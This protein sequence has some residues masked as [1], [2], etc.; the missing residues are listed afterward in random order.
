MNALQNKPLSQHRLPTPERNAPARAG[1]AAKAQQAQQQS[2]EQDSAAERHQS[3]DS[4][5]FTVSTDDWFKA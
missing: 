2:Q 1:D 3:A 4:D 5:T